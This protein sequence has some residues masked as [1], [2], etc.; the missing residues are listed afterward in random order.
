MSFA[1]RAETGPILGAIPNGLASEPPLSPTALGARPTVVELPVQPVA[2]AEPESEADPSPEGAWSVE[3][4]DAGPRRG[5]VRLL[6]DDHVE[7]DEARSRD[8]ALALAR[9]VVLRISAAE[10][11]GEWPELGG[12]LVRPGAIVSVDVLRTER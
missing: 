7:L 9:E 11:S 4:A 10:A 12:R 8:E 1:Q 5:V 2:P 6:G 3:D